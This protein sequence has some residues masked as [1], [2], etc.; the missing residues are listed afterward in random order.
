[1][2][3]NFGCDDSGQG[4]NWREKGADALTVQPPVLPLTLGNP[5]GSKYFCSIASHKINPQICR[6]HTNIAASVGMNNGYIQKK[7]TKHEALQGPKQRFPT[8][9][10][11]TELRK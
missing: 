7:H 1:M 10:Q 5:K 3:P 2:T 6:C 8:S 9:P 11:M 4:V